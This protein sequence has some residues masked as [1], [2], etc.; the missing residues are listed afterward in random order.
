VKILFAPAAAEAFAELPWPTKEKT[1]KSIELLETR[2]RIYP[3]RSR[4]LCVDI[5]ILSLA[6]IWS[7]TADAARGSK[8]I[9]I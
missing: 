3:I 9:G 4:A 6:N 5:A 1:G 7:T 2:P 8:S